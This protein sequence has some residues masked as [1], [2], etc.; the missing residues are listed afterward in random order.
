MRLTVRKLLTLLILTLLLWLTYIVANYS[1][2]DLYGVF[3]KV[4]MNYGTDDESFDR[5]DAKVRN[6]IHFSTYE[7]SDYQSFINKNSVENLKSLSIDK[8]CQLFFNH[9]ISS[10]KDWQF[11]RFDMPAFDKDI[12]NKRGYFNKI[13]KSIKQQRGKNY[14]IKNH[15][16]VTI[17]RDYRNMVRQSMK[18]EQQMADTMTL[19]RIYGK[20]FIDNNHIAELNPIFN[21]LTTKFF[22]SFSSILPRYSIENV[23]LQENSIPIFNNLNQFDGEFK[24][25]NSSEENF[26]H[27]FKKNSNGKG[28]LISATNRHSK[29]IAK[30]IRVL[31]ALNNRLPIQIVHRNDLKDYNREHISLVGTA[32]VEH[33][34]DPTSQE[35]EKFKPELDLLNQYKK[36][37]S[38]FPKQQ[39]FFV[40]ISKAISHASKRDFVGYSNKILALTFCSFKEVIVFDAD[41]VPLIPIE[42]FFN[43]AKYKLGGAYFFKDRSLR[44]YNDWV[45]TNYF[46]KLMPS[47]RESIDSLFDLKITEK[48]LNNTYMTGWRH[49]QEAGVIV[50][51]R[52]KHFVGIL[53]AIILLIWKEPVKSSVWGEKELYWLGLS[54]VGDEGYE[55]NT[56]AAG[57]VGQLST[58]PKFKYYPNFDAHEICSSHPGH[59]DE[60][61]KLLWINSGFDYCK[62][63]AYSS[64]LN[65]FPF[66]KIGGDEVLKMYTVPL[67]IDSLVVPPDLPGFREPGSPV[68]LDKESNLKSSWKSAKMDHDDINDSLPRGAKSV[69]QIL[70]LGPQ[71]GWI[72]SGICSGYQYCAFDFIESANS[73]NNKGKFFQYSP[74]TIRWVEYISKIWFTGQNKLKLRPTNKN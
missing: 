8:R 38:E 50:I 45:E 40:D 23:V 51:D 72:K 60:D 7:Y 37:G 16:I 61:G 27:F 41:S 39:I 4:V 58:N 49:F 11:Q 73:N 74:E 59:V 24:S 71:K 9:F 21:D 18:I 55:F 44:D 5:A 69:D 53:A 6:E 28:I 67:Q 13:A 34:L 20:C 56:L 32:D 54:M 3:F 70:D 1:Y 42:D 68:N 65:R 22:S 19:F 17:E 31:R 30:L 46:T 29:D 2:D 36:Y 62:K 33:L 66:L 26:I 10:N 48:T 43:H 25:F 52:Q 12:A 35:Y 63:N 64:D 57:S 14:Q 47:H 15:D